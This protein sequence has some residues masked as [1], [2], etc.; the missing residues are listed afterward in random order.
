MVGKI[1]RVSLREV[2]KHEAYDF[3]KWLEDNFE[4]LNEITELNLISVER[5]KSAG[6][7]SVDLVGEDLENNLVIIENQLEKSNHDHLGKLITY[8]TVLD[9]K[10]AIWIV[11]E[12]RPEH[13]QAISWLN[14]S[15]SGSFYLIKLEAIKIGDSEPAPL[16]TLIV[17]PSEESRETGQTKK[18]L[19]SRHTTRKRFWT[20]LLEYSKTHTKLFAS[21]SPSTGNW[22]GTSSGKSGLMFVFVANKSSTSVELYID[23]GKDKDQENEEIFDFLSNHSKEIEIAFEGPLSWESLE[24]RRA[25]RIRKKLNIGGRDDEEQWPEI[26]KSMVDAM[27]SLEKSFRPFINKLPI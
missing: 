18:D 23:R 10:S 5:E 21:I 11:S 6:K 13:I 20:E 1:Q 14:E 4:L 7:F 19:V 9:A 16:L 17:G 25:F 24:G 3:T 2:W 27:I 8:L 26:Q 12:P 15:S 22:I